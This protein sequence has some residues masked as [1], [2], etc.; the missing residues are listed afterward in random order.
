MQSS[1]FAV[2]AFSCA[3]I[4]SDGARKIARGRRDAKSLDGD[5]PANK[6]QDKHEKNFEI[7]SR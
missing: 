3:K 2:A 5:S 4:V 7:A 1:L 6:N